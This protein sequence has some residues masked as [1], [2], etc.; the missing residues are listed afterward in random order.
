ML[1]NDSIDPHRLPVHV[2]IIMD[3]NG[4]W[5]RNRNKSR[6]YGHR[7]G[8]KAAK[9]VVRAASDIGLKNL[10][11]YVF[12]TENW[13]RAESEVSYLMLLIRTH[14]KKELAFYRENGIK[15]IHSGD[16]EGLPREISQEIQNAMRD[17]ATYQGLTVNLAINYGGRDEIVRAIKRWLKEEGK[18]GQSVRNLRFE[19]S[20]IG[21]FLDHPELPDPDLIIRTS[22]EMRTSNFLLWE[23]TYSE[24]YFSPKLWPDWT[25]EDLLEAI[26]CYQKRERRFGAAE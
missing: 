14:L 12:S 25:G 5:A 7:E 19:E 4:R 11:L 9:R 18:N 13:R 17:T 6:R 1:T 20:N 22:G 16:A 3:G 2:G 21:R 24:L 26:S 15:V 23:S 8:L 10:S